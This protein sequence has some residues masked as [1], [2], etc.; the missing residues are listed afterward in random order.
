MTTAPSTTDDTCSP[1]A[2]LAIG[3]EAAASVATTLKALAEPLRLRMLSAIASDPR[4]ES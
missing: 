3:Q 1:V 4:G 2:T